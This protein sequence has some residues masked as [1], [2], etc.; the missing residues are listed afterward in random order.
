MYDKKPTDDRTLLLVVSGSRAYGTHTAESDTDIKGVFVAE[1]HEIDGIYPLTDRDQT[2][3]RTAEFVTR[4]D[5][6]LVETD[7]S[8]HEISKFCRLAASCNPTILETLW[9]DAE[10][11]ISVNA[12]GNE[13]IQL[14]TDFLSASG[15]RNAYLGYATSQLRRMTQAHTDVSDPRRA[16]HAKQLRRLL[17]AGYQLWSTGDMRVKVDDPEDFHMFGERCRADAT[18]ALIES[19]ITDYT[20]LFDETPT[21]LPNE[22]DLSRAHDLVKRVR[23]AYRTHDRRRRSTGNR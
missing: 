6:A 5:G 19:V 1:Q 4:P 20:I 13:L 11:V 3:V 7:W 8:L 16:K 15:V 22:P 12:Y 18:N 21:A 9:T 2:F 23:N 10:D 17:M 14:R